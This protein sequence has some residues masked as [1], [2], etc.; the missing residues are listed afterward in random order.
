MALTLGGKSNTG[1]VASSLK[2]FEGYLQYVYDILNNGTPEQMQ[3]LMVGRE[4]CG[5][6]IEL[7]ANAFQQRIREDTPQEVVDALNAWKENPTDFYLMFSAFLSF[8]TDNAK[9]P[10]LPIINAEQK[11]IG[12][13]LA[14]FTLG[15]DIDVLIPLLTS[16]S[17][18]KMVQLTRSNSF[19]QQEG[20]FDIEAV[21]NY[22]NHPNISNIAP[23]MNSKVKDFLEEMWQND[24]NTTNS[25]FGA[26]GYVNRL[27]STKGGRITLLKKLNAKIENK[28]SKDSDIQ[29]LRRFRDRIKA[30]SDLQDSIRNEEI[31]IP[32]PDGEG[33]ISIKVFPEITKLELMHKEMLN[34][35]KIARLNQGL[36]NTVDDLINWLRSFESIISKRINQGDMLDPEQA[37]KAKEALE[38]LNERTL[39]IPEGVENRSE[40]LHQVNLK[41]F[42]ENESY[43][44]GIINIYESLKFA[45]NIFAAADD[46]LHYAGYQKVVGALVTT[47]EG[48]SATWHLANHIS[49]TIDSDKDSTNAII[50]WV[51]SSTITEFLSSLNGEFSIITKGNP[52]FIKSVGNNFV[53]NLK[54]SEP[55]EESNVVLG[56]TEG[57]ATFKY[58]VENIV[59]PRLK[60]TYKNNDLLKDL[61]ITETDKTIDHNSFTKLTTTTKLIP[62]NDFERQVIN[63]YKLGL[64][65]IK[66]AEIPELAMFDSDGNKL[67]NLNFLDMLFLYNLIVNENKS[68]ESNL[69]ILFQDFVFSSNAQSNIINSYF[70]FRKMQEPYLVSKIKDLT[71]QDIDSYKQSTA[72]L[73][74]FPISER[75]RSK[76]KYILVKDNTNKVVL[77]ER[78]NDNKEDFS[79]EEDYSSM[80][81]QADINS[82]SFVD[83]YLAQEAE[84]SEEF[85][86][87]SSF[88]QF[89]DSVEEN[90]YRIRGTITSLI[91]SA[92]PTSST[93]RS[94]IEEMHIPVELIKSGKLDPKVL[95]DVKQNPCS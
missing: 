24:P 49:S 37:K 50:N 83:E 59:I 76:N 74:K 47:L 72:K 48:S 45:V 51:N 27:L 78:I 20:L 63:K 53:L 58:I 38:A 52:H 10:R 15:I 28:N 36:P 84:D 54:Q 25:E 17:A 62:S 65:Y 56:T 55:S 75:D 6:K 5:K 73:F 60:K 66:D 4:I 80:F 88:E 79:D 61:T 95:T 35:S 2:V 21:I 11:M 87:Y 82:D 14:G 41:A 71:V 3:K 32:N 67:G 19:N 91:Y 22:I 31:E 69:T 85:E 93:L 29:S 12:L 92:A 90:G 42:V 57:N 40:L 89:R 13:Y 8:A 43:R 68:G 30:Y 70:E 33:T 44:K 26:N 39:H 81:M 9:D 77:C 16:K 23:P 7:L 1:I 46:L 64:N 34:F 94:L 86:G 18:L